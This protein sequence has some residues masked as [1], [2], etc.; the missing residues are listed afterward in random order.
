M[1]EDRQ[2][3]KPRAQPKGAVCT[4]WA[5]S[6]MA[7]CQRLDTLRRRLAAK[8]KGRSPGFSFDDKG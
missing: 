5:T 6:V 2:D 1:T 8:Y 4:P 3:T 7:H